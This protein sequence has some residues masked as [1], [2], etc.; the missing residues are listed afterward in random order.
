MTGE[1]D[2]I[3]HV[4]SIVLQKCIQGFKYSARLKVPKSK[5]KTKIRHFARLLLKIPR[6]L[7]Y[8]KQNMQ[9]DQSYQSTRVFDKLDTNKTLTH[10]KFNNICI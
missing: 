5:A 8:G 1:N 9:L 2:A 3:D 4:I 10:S 6:L 7:A